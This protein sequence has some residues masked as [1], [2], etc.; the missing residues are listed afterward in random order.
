MKCP[1]CQTENPDNKKYCRECGADLV[2]NCPKCGAEVLAGDKFCGDYRYDLRKPL[3]AP[4]IEYSKPQSY[5][6]KNLADKILT[7][8]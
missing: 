7:S 1:S 3:E 8:K 5:T 2:L 4:P 6:P